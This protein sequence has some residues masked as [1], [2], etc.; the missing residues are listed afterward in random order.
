M[1]FPDSRTGYTQS[2]QAPAGRKS[3]H[4]ERCQRQRVRPTWAFRGMAGKISTAFSQVACLVRWGLWVVVGPLPRYHHNHA[5]PCGRCTENRAFWNPAQ[6]YSRREYLVS[7][8]NLPGTRHSMDSVFIL[9]TSP[10]LEDGKTLSPPT[11]FG[12]GERTPTLK[13]GTCSPRSMPLS[14]PVEVD[15]RI[16]GSLS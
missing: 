15:S 7:P 12:S 2:G 13:S 8:P 3:I 11:T 5:A 4:R 1:N 9:F 14:S 6:H 10:T 16:S